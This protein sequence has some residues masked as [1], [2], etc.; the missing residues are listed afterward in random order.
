MRILVAHN[1]YQQAGGEDQVFKAE[2][3]LLRQYGHDVYVF[4]AHND[5]M[6]GLNKLKQAQ[7]TLWSRRSQ[8]ELSTVIRKFQPDIAHFHNTFMV[9]SPS[10]YSA[11][12]KAGVPV[13][14]TLHNYRL[15]CPAAVLYR[16]GEICDDCA[17]KSLALPAIQHGCYRDSRAASAVV[18][19]HNA[20]MR[21][22]RHAGNVT[23]YIAISEAVR[24]LF[25]RAG[26]EP[27]RV[28]VKPNFLANDPGLR[29]NAPRER[30]LYV[31]RFT[32]EKGV[33]TLI[34]AL[35]QHPNVPVDMVGDGPAF[36]SVRQRIADYGLNNI[37]LHGQQSHAATLGF[38]QRAR[39][40]IVPS[41][42]RE[43][44]GLVAIEAF[45]C[46]TPV[47]AANIGGLGEI[48]RDAQ[49]GYH[50]EAGSAESLASAIARLCRI[51]QP[52][53]QTM[54]AN[55]RQT[56]ERDYTASANYARLKHIY[57]VTRARYSQRTAVT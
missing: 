41:E 46:G 11:C 16:D 29:A 38:L 18:V 22:Q 40:L 19:A 39:G 30:L 3:A 55:V 8:S 52:T 28:M 1:Y 6:D 44:F 21:R 12:A 5:R 31:G 50:F 49:H 9:M 25:L 34:D 33:L 7:V 47:I 14:Q 53:W 10:V 13:V 15:I 51:D 56:Y 54:S 37:T 24:S 4:T 35:R 45:A 32:Q 42:W 23:T 17:G 57:D 2:I 48:V 27:E 26:F 43:P 20:V 36:E